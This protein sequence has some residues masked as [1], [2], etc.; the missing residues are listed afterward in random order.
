MYWRLLPYLTQAAN[1]SP[2]GY[3]SII[4][5][6][7]WASKTCTQGLSGHGEDTVA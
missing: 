4:T 5:G 6:V 1:S 2:R 7:E 3:D